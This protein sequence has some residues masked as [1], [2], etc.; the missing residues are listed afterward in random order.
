MMP[1]A[2][3]SI[4]VSCLPHERDRVEL[5]YLENSG[6]DNTR[7]QKMFSYGLLVPA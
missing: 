4:V 3:G 6:A 5:A 1:G 2:P 7:L